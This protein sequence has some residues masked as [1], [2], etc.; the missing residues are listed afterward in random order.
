MTG[1]G[2]NDYGQQSGQ[3]PNYGAPPPP[4]PQ[5]GYP[6]PGYPPAGYPPPGYPAYTPPPGPPPTPPSPPRKKRFNRGW[7]WL[8]AALALV[9]LVAYVTDEESPG[10][11]TGAQTTAPTAAAPAAPSPSGAAMQQWS[12]RATKHFRKARD[13][14][15]AIQDCA[16][17]DDLECIKQSCGTV[18]DAMTI[19]LKGD[20]PSP[21]PR[22]TDALNSA[23]TEFDTGMHICIGMSASTTKAHAEEMF[24]HLDRAFGHLETARA[25]MDEHLGTGT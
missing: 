3:P 13:G 21:D 25:I 17:R 18:H 23:I 4:P 16:E 8:A 1:F 2:P 5:P 24:A 14:F 22:L 15:V 20:L 7:F 19:D 6:P 9:G 10:P 11:G 12:Q